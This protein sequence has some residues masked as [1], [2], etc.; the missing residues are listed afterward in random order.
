MSGIQYNKSIQ[1]T[2]SS[3]HHTSSFKFL[4]QDDFI[5]EAT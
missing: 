5:K 2:Q 4:L 3:R 1:Q